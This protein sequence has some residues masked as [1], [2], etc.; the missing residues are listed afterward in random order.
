MTFSHPLPTPQQTA[1]SAGDSKLIGLEII[2][3]LAAFAVL[4]WHYQHFWYVGDAPQDFIRSEQPLYN[5]LRLFYEHGVYGVHVFWGISGYIFFWKYRSIIAEHRIGGWKF[6]VLRFSRLYPLHLITFM[7]VAGLQ[8]LHRQVDGGDFIFPADNLS[9]ALSHLYMGSQW[10]RGAVQTFNGPIWSVSLEVLVYGVFYLCT[11]LTRGSHLTSVVL[12][13]VGGVAYQFKIHPV[14]QCLL[15]FYL[16]GLAATFHDMPGLKA[17]HARMQRFSASRYL[18]ITV[19]VLMTIP[20]LVWGGS[21][22]AMIHGYI[23]V[24]L[25][26]VLHLFGKQIWIPESAVH[27]VTVAGN[28]TYASYL[29][30]FPMQLIVKLGFEVS[31]TPIPRDEPLFL[32]CY[33]IYVALVSILTYRHVEVPLQDWLRARLLKSRVTSG[34]KA[35]QRRPVLVTPAR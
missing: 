30:H 15:L 10:A 27:A 34:T 18:P 6:F 4:I 22:K 2:R 29:L 26:F 5:L 14:F 9:V 3:F 19:I 12:A 20:L 24:C 28:I 1:P 21:H 7:L 31:G 8:F 35:R 16:G 33:L 32:A 17:I 23:L 11:W 13:I 25:P